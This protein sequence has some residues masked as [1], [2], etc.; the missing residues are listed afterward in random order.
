M[1]C[2]VDT[3]AVMMLTAGPPRVVVVGLV[4]ITKAYA[5]ADPPPL[6]RGA[7]VLSYHTRSLTAA[8]TTS[9]THTGCKCIGTHIV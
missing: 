5:L 8:H 9:F 4:G 1:D 3:R 2:I 6:Q 7:V